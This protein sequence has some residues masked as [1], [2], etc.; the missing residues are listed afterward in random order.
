MFDGDNSYIEHKAT[1]TRTPVKQ[2]NG[3]FVIE[4][5]LE[6]LVQ[7]NAAGFGRPGR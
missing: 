7:K 4:V 3:V 1:G 5:N 6:N 2:R